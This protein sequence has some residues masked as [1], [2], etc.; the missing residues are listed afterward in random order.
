MAVPAGATPGLAPT[1]TPL[2]AGFLINCVLYG[3]LAN[4]VYWY[5][6][7]F[8]KDSTQLKAFVGVLAFVETAQTAMICYDALEGYAINLG[9]L[10]AFDDVH[11]AW[12]DIPITTSIISLLVQSF[13]AWRIFKLSKNWYIVILVEMVALLQTGAAFAAGIIIHSL[14]TYSAVPLSKGATDSVKIWLAASAACDVLIA[15]IMVYLLNRT[16][17]QFHKTKALVSKLIKMTIETGAITAVFAVIVVILFSTA[18]GSYY[19]C[20]G[21]LVAKLYSNVALAVLNSRIRVMGGRDDSHQASTTQMYVDASQGR[22]GR[23][24]TSRGV[25][26]VN[27]TRTQETQLDADGAKS[28]SQ[29]DNDI[30]MH[31]LPAEFC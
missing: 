29:W 22:G 1:T 6:M 26:A 10:A 16:P 3:V 20:L 19:A 5:Y 8:P 4:Q 14:K 12:M 30:P 9:S 11:L 25:F 23:Q 27:V 31:P 15:L 7:S 18:G 13:F 24:D 2:L 28:T 21:A 17:T